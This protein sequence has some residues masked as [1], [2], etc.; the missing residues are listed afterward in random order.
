V[1]SA[2]IQQI[3][4]KYGAPAW[5]AAQQQVRVDIQLDIWW[6]TGLAIVAAVLVLGTVFCAYQG[7]GRDYSDWSMGAFVMGVLVV[8]TLFAIALVAGDLYSITQ[9]PTGRAIQHLHD[10]VVGRAS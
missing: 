6:L 4:D 2:E 1:S 5:A 8:V 10:Y 9:N 7:Y 3:I